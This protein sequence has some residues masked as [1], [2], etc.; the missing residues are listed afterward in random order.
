MNPLKN[1][2]NSGK[3]NSPLNMLIQVLKSGGN[4]NALLN[5]F[6]QSNPDFAEIMNMVRNQ[7]PQQLEQIC[8]N[9]CKKRGIDFDEAYNT[10]RNMMK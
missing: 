1:M 7:S 5:S 8:R 10:V 4:P 2:F 9:L 6:A 3:S